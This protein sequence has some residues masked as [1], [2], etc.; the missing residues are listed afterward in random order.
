MKKILTIAILFI[1]QI[2]FGQVKTWKAQGDGTPAG[3]GESKVAQ[4]IS[5]SLS[6]INLSGYSE[7]QVDSI[8]AQIRSEILLKLNK[9]DSVIANRVTANTA[10]IGSKASITSL[11]PNISFWLPQ[12]IHA[13]EGVESNIYL[14][15]AIYSDFGK[16]DLNYTVTC[17]KGQLFDRAWTFTPLAGDS[18]VYAFTLNVFYKGILIA[19]KLDSLYVTT[20]RAGNGVRNVLSCGNSLWEQGQEVDTIKSNYG[21]DALSLNFVGKMT[22]LGGNKI[23]AIGGYAWADY[24]TFGQ[25]FY[26]LTVSGVSVNPSVGATYSTNGSVFIVRY[27]NISSG[28]GTLQVSRTSG[29]TT[30]VS[31][32][33]V[34]TKTTGT[35]DASVSFSLS[36]NV[37]GNPFWNNSTS[38]IDL[39]NYLTINSITLNANDWITFELGVNDMISYTDT[40][41]ASN[42]VR[43]SIFT[44]VDSIIAQFRRDVP[45]IRIGILMPA[46]PFSQDGFGVRFNNSQTAWR[47]RINLDIY[48]KN[49][50]SKYDTPAMQASGTYVL[51]LGNSIDI[52]NN[53]NIVPTPVNARNK[54][55]YMR[56]VDP[57][58]PLSSGYAQYA[59]CYYSFLK[60]FK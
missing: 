51:G 1:T 53:T 13:I 29:V 24:A 31:V 38:K 48:Y 47:H 41:S 14:Y 44:Y 27:I 37:S 23:Q 4:M 33:G 34:L 59:D 40:V 26:S 8:T 43:T 50:L 36:S 7:I 54:T 20:R 55:T 15:N 32:G 39:G 10:A 3:I 35:G 30:P 9:S 16:A 25:T 2:T 17:A 46:P 5:D 42:Y 19:S 52:V 21:S 28:S 18:G 57:L 11:I 45:G 49:M 6:K 12:R 56:N 60:W 58:H 22:T